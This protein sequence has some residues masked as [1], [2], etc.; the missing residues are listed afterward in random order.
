MFKLY[1]NV[2]SFGQG[3]K[4]VGPQGNAVGGAETAQLQFC[5][6]VL[7][8]T[9]VENFAHQ[10][11]QHLCVA[12]HHEQL[13]ATSAHQRGVRQQ[14]FGRAC[15]QRERC[16]Q[17]VAH[18]GKELQLRLCHLGHMFGHAALLFNAVF[19]LAVYAGLQK[20]ATHGIG[21]GHHQQHHYK[22]QHQQVGLLHMHVGGSLV[23]T[24]AQGGKVVAL[25]HRLVVLHQ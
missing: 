15:Y 23:Y 10:L 6:I 13:L 16:A 4:I 8:L 3:F 9:E 22:Q 25:A 2:F 7:H 19:Q 21:T 18:I 1:L 17:F 20:V 5:L 12:L 24:A 11:Y 14:L